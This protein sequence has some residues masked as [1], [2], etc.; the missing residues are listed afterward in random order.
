MEWFGDVLQSLMKL[1]A[2]FVLAAGAFLVVRHLVLR[3]SWVLCLLG[4]SATAMQMVVVPALKR[5]E[6]G[7][8]ASHSF[9][10]YFA[11]LQLSKMV[12]VEK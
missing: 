2:T 4:T 8:M 11:T 9:W 12:D 7:L 10:E 5:E 3:F 6:K 1:Q